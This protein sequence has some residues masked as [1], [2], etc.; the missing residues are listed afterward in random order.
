MKN[1]TGPNKVIAID[2]YSSCGKSSFA[3]LIAKETGYLYVD[4]GAMY[5]AI[6]LFCLQKGLIDRKG[7]IDLQALEEALPGVEISFCC[8]VG[9]GENHVCLNGV[10]VEDRI[11][12][13]DV[14]EH[15]SPV[16][17]ILMVRRK[18]VELQR[19]ISRGNNVVMDGRDIGTVV[20]P[21][22]DL[23]IFMTASPKIRAERRH[24]ELLEKGKNISLEEVEQNLLER[25]FIDE[26]REESPLRKAVDALVIDN[27][28]MSLED[29]MKWFREIFK[30]QV[31]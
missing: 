9:S 11:R 2:G 16:S 23:K 5:R 29:E 8:Q 15:V 24:K 10:D 31:G 19:E 25:D 3:R 27:S 30:Q 20:F 7:K 12:E 13:M 17:K 22:A 21:R 18:M 6:T 1:A 28:Q 14:S 4:S 26:N